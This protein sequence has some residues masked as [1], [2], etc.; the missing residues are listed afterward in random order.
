EFRR[1][2]PDTGA[3]EHRGERLQLLVSGKC[4][5]PHQPAEVGAL[6]DQ[7]IETFEIGLDR[8]DRLRLAGEVEQ[9]GR[10]AAGHA[11]YEGFFGGQIVRSRY[12][13]SQSRSRRGQP[14]QASGSSPWLR[15][16]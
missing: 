5:A 11:G 10:V 2:A 14:A 1:K 13:F 6:R 8:V 7:R 4:P 15:R 9:R 3:V 12:A 16:T